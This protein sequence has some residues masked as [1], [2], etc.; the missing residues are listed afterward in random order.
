L[1]NAKDLL[2]FQRKYK[3]WLENYRQYRLDFC[4]N[5]LTPAKETKYK[6]EL[7]ELV[8][9]LKELNTIYPEGNLYDCQ[10]SESINP[11][12]LGNTSLGTL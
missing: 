1:V 8:L 3:I 4:S 7:N 2:T 10:L 11:I 12:I 5:K 9:A 6:T